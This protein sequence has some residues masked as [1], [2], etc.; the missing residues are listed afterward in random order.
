MNYWKSSQNTNK[1][2]VLWGVNWIHIFS[3]FIRRATTM[4]PLNFRFFIWNF[5]CKHE[6]QTSIM[7]WRTTATNK[8][9][10][11]GKH[12]AQQHLPWQTHISWLFFSLVETFIDE[13]PVCSNLF[14]CY[15]HH[16]RCCRDHHHGCRRRR[17]HIG[18][19]I[20]LMCSTHVKYYFVEEKK[21]FEPCHTG[22]TKKK[23]LN[24]KNIPW[25]IYK[26]LHINSVKYPSYDIFLCVRICVFVFSAFVC[27]FP[28]NEFTYNTLFICSKQ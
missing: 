17:R 20:K 16:R 26:R 28:S 7:T 2:I 6:I 11:H 19:S 3:L 15:H 25:N 13:F 8:Q 27:V 12:F 24:K 14:H 23:W 1:K 5:A 9:S 18:T 10:T 4:P 21:K 22:G